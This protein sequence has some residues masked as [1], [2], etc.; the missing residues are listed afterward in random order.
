MNVPCK[1]VD[2]LTPAEKIAIVESADGQIEEVAVSKENLSGESLLADE[3]GRHE[4]KV[5]VEL[6][7]ETASGRWRIWVKDSENRHSAAG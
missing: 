1:I 5:L 4:G 2:G 3:I 7:R 6:P